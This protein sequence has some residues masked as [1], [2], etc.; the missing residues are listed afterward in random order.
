MVTWPQLLIHPTRKTV[1]V[2]KLHEILCVCTLCA[3]CPLLDVGQVHLT[4]AIRLMLV[5]LM[6]QL[7]MD[8]L[9]T[10]SETLIRG[11]E[12]RGMKVCIRILSLYNCSHPLKFNIRHDLGG[13]NV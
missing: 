12:G 8:Q 13:Y 10:H 1:C 7:R 11:S 6:L 4:T 3:F 9:N 2:K 5:I